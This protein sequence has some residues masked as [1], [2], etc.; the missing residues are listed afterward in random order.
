MDT[1]QEQSST[2]ENDLSVLSTVSAD[3]NKKVLSPRNI[4]VLGGIF[5]LLVLVVVAIVLVSVFHNPKS[6]VDTFV[7]GGNGCPVVQALSLDDFSNPEQVS[8]VPVQTPIGTSVE[9]V[10][11]RGSRADFEHNLADD[12]IVGFPK[13]SQNPV[14]KDP[15]SVKLFYQGNLVMYATDR[16][17]VYFVHLP[18]RTAWKGEQVVIPIPDADSNTFAPLQ[19][20]DDEHSYTGF[21]VDKNHVYFLGDAIPNITPNTFRLLGHS[22]ALASDTTGAL[23]LLSVPENTTREDGPVELSQRILTPLEATYIKSLTGNE[24]STSTPNIVFTELKEPISGDA[25]IRPIVRFETGL[26]RRNLP[27]I[28][29][30][31]KS[32]EEKP[33][34]CFAAEDY[35]VRSSLFYKSHALLQLLFRGKPMLVNVDLSSARV[36]STILPLDLVYYSQIIFDTP[37]Q[38]LWVLKNENGS[39]GAESWRPCGCCFSV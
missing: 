15:A 8:W 14:F 12:T 36:N 23:I 7:D 32:G 18:N 26:I 22:Y 37:N 1:P 38:S 5:A 16:S 19:G 9:V 6:G 3:Q 24:H 11:P 21:A 13:I 2:P 29:G 28:Y 35:L 17:N 31:F 20:G 33:S 27:S 4:K 10:A 39:G 34:V 25:E 30:V